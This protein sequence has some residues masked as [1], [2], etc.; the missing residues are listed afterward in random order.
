MLRVCRHLGRAVMS[1]DSKHNVTIAKDL[2]IADLILQH[3]H[4]GVG[5]GGRNHILS[6]LHQKY[7]IPGAGALI[8]GVDVCD[9]QTMEPQFNSKWPTCPQAVTPEK[10][11][12]SFVGVDYFGQFEVKC[13]RSLVKK[14]GVIF[15]CSVI[16]AIHIEVAS[17]LDT[18]L[19][20]KL[21]DVSLFC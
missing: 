11:P 14:Y 1:E 3:I 12:F 17:S 21:Y 18:D 13:E 16:R 7:W 2:H 5:H 4:K 20:L 6:K 9:V 19:S 8:R 10:P 15:T